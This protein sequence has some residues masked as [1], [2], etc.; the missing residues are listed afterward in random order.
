MLCKVSLDYRLQPFIVLTSVDCSLRG[1]T[2]EMQ[3]QSTI[4]G[5]VISKC[6][7]FSLIWR[8]NTCSLSGNMKSSWWSV[9]GRQHKG[10]NIHDTVEQEEGGHFRFLL[11]MSP[12][13]RWKSRGNFKMGKEVM[14]VSFMLDTMLGALYIYTSISYTYTYIHSGLLA[15]RNKK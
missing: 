13:R 5:E 2:K 3:V 14:Q 11:G 10:V 1:S 12:D 6:K 7:S 9:W 4:R 15:L 8:H